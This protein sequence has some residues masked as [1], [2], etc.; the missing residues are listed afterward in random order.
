MIFTEKKITISNNQCKIDSPVVL[1]RGDYNVEVRFTLISSPYKYSKK[2]SVNIIEQTEASFG[3]LV[4]KT[5]NDKPTIFSERTPTNNGAITFVITGEMI[6]EINELG[7][8]T[9]QIILFGMYTY[10]VH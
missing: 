5:P 10:Q 7:K 6:D 2:D 9:F 3:Q 1:Y 8:Y 4:I